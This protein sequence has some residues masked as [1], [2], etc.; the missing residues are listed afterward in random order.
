MWRRTGSMCLYAVLV[1]LAAGAC[2]S[3]SQTAPAA[4]AVTQPDVAMLAGTWQGFATMSGGPGGLPVTVRVRP[5]GSYAS[6]VGASSGTGTFV[7]RDG[8][9]VTTGHLSGSAFGSEGRGTAVLQQ[10]QGRLTLV[11]E[12]RNDR[13]PYSYELVK[14]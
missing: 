13:G 9:I 8:S 2:A 5:D 3:S 7:V 4:S 10:K 1:V 6:T 14:N 12:G 11:G